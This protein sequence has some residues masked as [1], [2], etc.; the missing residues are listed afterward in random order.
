MEYAPDVLMRH[1]V[2]AV[3][4]VMAESAGHAQVIANVR[5]E[6][7]VRAVLVPRHCAAMIKKI[8]VREKRAMKTARI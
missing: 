7:F 1:N 6:M 3:R 5:P 4:F 2:K 8:P